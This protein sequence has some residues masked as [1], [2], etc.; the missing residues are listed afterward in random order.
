[1]RNSEWTKYVEEILGKCNDENPLHFFGYGNSLRRDDGV[2]LYIISRLLRT[3]KEK[4][5]YI[6]I[7]S[8]STNLEREVKQ[9]PKSSRIIIIDSVKTDEPPGTIIFTEFRKVESYLFDTHNIS[10]RFIL[11]INT[12]LENSYLLG[13][14]PQD[15]EIGE[16]LTPIVKESADTIIIYLSY[17][18]TAISTSKTR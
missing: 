16:E 2:G 1:M 13:V 9:I 14:V 17:L 6:H 8:V 11:E 5:R 3:V 12:L 7:H 4:P 15:T 10:L 18:L